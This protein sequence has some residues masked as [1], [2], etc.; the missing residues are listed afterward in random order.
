MT[1]SDAS[2]KNPV[3]AWM[4]MAALVLLGGIGFSRLGVSQMPDVDFPVVTVSVTL[5]GAAPEILETDV[6]DFIEDAVMTVE[7]VR[8]V[9][10]SCKSGSASV[11]VEFNLGRNIDAALQDVQ[12]K[13]AQAQRRLPRDM[14]PPVVT[15]TNPEDQ[16]IMWVALSGGRPPQ[17][18]ADLVR[19]QLKDR[20]QTVPGVGEVMMGGYLDRNVRIWLDLDGLD[21][22]RVTV[23]EVLAA[24]QREHLEVPAGRIET[25]A[26]E[27]NV[28]VE[29]EALSLDELRNLAVAHRGG[30]PIYL[31]EVA[32]V[33]DG[34]EDVRRIARYMGMP[35]QGMGIKKRRGANAVEVARGVRARV[36]ELTAT[37]PADLQLVVVFDSTAYIEESISEIEFTLVLSVIITAVVCWLF[38]GSWSSTTNILLAIPTSI[39]GTF[40]AMYFLG[41][42]LNTFTLLALSLSVGIVVDDAIMVMENIV[43]HAEGGKDRVRA[44]TDGTRQIAFAA[45]AATAAIIAIFLP[46]AFMKGIIGVF[47]FQFGITLSVSVALSLLEALTLTPS[48]CAQFLNVN[49]RTSGVGATAD[50]VFARLSRAYLASLRWV[51]GHRVTV[52]AT[53]AA[54]F[55]ASLFITTRLNKEFVPSQDQSRFLVRIMTPVG[56]SIEATDAL[57]RRCEEFCMGRPGVNK[58]FGS[59]GGFGGGDINTG[60]LFVTL[61]PRAQREKSMIEMIGEFRT[62]LNRIPGVE[63]KVQDLS[64]SGLSAQ[65]G[66]PIEYSIRGPELDKLAELSRQIMDGMKESGLCVDV[67]TDYLIGQPEAKVRPDRAKAADLGVDMAEIGT[68]VNALIG[69]VRVGKFKARGRRYDIRARLLRGQRV[70]PE[71]LKRLWVRN[72]GGDLIQMSDMVE[73]VERPTLQVIQRRARQRAVAVFGNVAPGKSQAAALDAVE[74]IGRELLPEGYT[75]TATGNAATFRD[76][77]AGYGFA[78]GLGLAIAYM[79]LASQF[80][81]FLHPVTIL[82]ALP[83]SVTGALV[84]LWLGGV[85]INMYSMLGIVLLMGIVKKNSILLVDYTNQVRAGGAERDAAL[86]EACPVRLRP[87]LM[88]SMSTIAGALPGALAVGPGGEVRI[89]MCLAVIGGVMVSTVLTLVV[90]PA[91]YSLSD[92][93]G[94]RVRAW[95]AGR[96]ATKGG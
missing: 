24:L 40:G 85:S 34:F 72:R 51:L 22:Y 74:Q 39:I 70:R 94:A 20:L 36:A 17:E 37:L 3:F 4:L 64:Q 27:V 46:V 41:F 60:V 81:S 95:W 6:V 79:I 38:L 71:D 42:T 77:G 23:G 57:M 7:G 13:I 49:E 14:D 76:S 73:V 68:T 18:L 93:G 69:G 44:A 61:V 54:L 63:A 8:E 47:L 50:R 11:T 35:S 9:S 92:A 19:F 48:R 62:G 80:N 53:A 43:R 89:P 75:I 87:I 67:D 84:A 29:G 66:F 56:S 33:Q 10:S 90:V 59:V 5:E 55:V 86:L 83:F 32:V 25:S 78:I 30:R 15:K 91:F 21:A 31:R 82:L 45:M 96:R 58:V 65:R 2:I 88:T 12:T 16:P 28:R 52:C 26:R 1:L